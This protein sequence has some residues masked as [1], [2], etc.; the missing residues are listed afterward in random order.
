MGQQSSEWRREKLKE[1][2]PILRFT[3]VTL[4]ISFH[5]STSQISKTHRLHPLSS[6]GSFRITCKHCRETGFGGKGVNMIIPSS[7]PAPGLHILSLTNHQLF[8]FLASSF[9]KNRQKEG[10]KLITPQN[11]ISSVGSGT[12]V[13]SLQ[14]LFQC[15]KQLT[16]FSSSSSSSGRFPICFLSYNIN[17][18]LENDS[19]TT[20]MQLHQ[21][22]SVMIGLPKHSKAK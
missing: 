14:S 1:K 4:S 18:Q 10:K 11:A 16:S 2:L 22:V 7:I 5:T 21:L 9:Q 13:S 15:V 17:R 8:I 12:T 6:L 19:I 3:C 20:F